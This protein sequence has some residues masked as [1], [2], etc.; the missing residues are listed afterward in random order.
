[1]YIYDHHTNTH[2]RRALIVAL[3]TSRLEVCLLSLSCPTLWKAEAVVAVLPFFYLAPHVS[4]SMSATVVLENGHDENPIRELWQRR[5]VV[6]S[7]HWH[8][9]W[10]ELEEHPTASSPHQKSSVRNVIV[11]HQEQHSHDVT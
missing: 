9:G 7:S 3:V 11:M 4:V 1:M 2:I 8:L 5:M 6:T 10:E